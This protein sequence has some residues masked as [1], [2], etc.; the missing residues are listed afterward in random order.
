MKSDH[1]HELKTNE[2]ADWLA[3]FP[4]WAKE[5]RTTLI[6]AAVVIVVAAAV[7]FWVFYQN[8][9][10]SARTQVRLTNL[11]TQLPTQKG[12]I[13][14]SLSQGT[15]QS[16]VL[17][18]VARDLQE[19][20]Q[21]AK[22]DEM[23]ALAL[24]DRAEAIRAE[25][26][27][28]LGNVSKAELAKQIALA[29]ASYQKALE[30]ASGT[31]ALAAKAQFGLGLC[32]EELGDFDKAR[33]IYQTVASNADY[34]GTVAQVE[35]EYRLE[36]MA[37]YKGSVVFKLAPEPQPEAVGPQAS[38]PV[39]RVTPGDANAPIVIPMPNDIGVAPTAP[40]PEPESD[41]LPDATDAVEVLE[42]NVPA[43]G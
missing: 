3:H 36:T 26:H 1:R 9:V 42:V 18:D 22:D 13:A 29:Q 19:F 25:L 17:L 21:S 30:R 40:G 43:G 15:D 23:A 12:A 20:A 16:Y 4:Q 5:N 35:A 37:D 24:I 11:V 34:E 38:G 6:G 33:E 32:E 10:V 31:P 41:V 8:R 28:R 7:Y 2:L 27:Y 14:R 39:V